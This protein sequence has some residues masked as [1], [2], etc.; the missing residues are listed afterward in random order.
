MCYYS[1]MHSKKPPL[2]IK[3]TP[4]RTIITNIIR[5]NFLRV[6]GEKKNLKMSTFKNKQQ[7]QTP[8]G[9]GLVEPNTLMLHTH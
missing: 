6:T 3:S 8:L 2:T 7:Q 9:S 4:T 1:L 5:L